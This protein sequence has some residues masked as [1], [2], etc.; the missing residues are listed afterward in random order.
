MT[1][2][3]LADPAGH[4]APPSPRELLAGD[5]V[6]AE[7]DR[8]AAARKENTL[9]YRYFVINRSDKEVMIRAGGLRYENFR[10]SFSIRPPGFVPWTGGGRFF[11][12]TTHES[13]E[14]R[15]RRLR[16]VKLFPGDC[17]GT[18]RYVTRRD[19]FGVGGL[20]TGRTSTINSPWGSNLQSRRTQLVDGGG[21]TRVWHVASPRR[22]RL[23]AVP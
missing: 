17:F 5:E 18:T 19:E 9:E 15:E 11:A 7:A 4:P 10:Q 12:A 21:R 20:T 14:Q 23:S 13:R 22:R 1:R 3:C 16:I 6:E 8:L 2:T